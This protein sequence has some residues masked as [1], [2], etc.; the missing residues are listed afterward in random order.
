M[1]LKD[2]L[3]EDEILVINSEPREEESPV[4]RSET[5]TDRFVELKGLFYLLKGVGWGD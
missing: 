1:S 5:E 3:D 2:E 4:R